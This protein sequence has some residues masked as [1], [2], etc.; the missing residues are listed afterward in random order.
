MNIYACCLLEVIDGD[1]I[2][3]HVSFG[4]GFYCDAYIRLEE[5]DAPEIFGVGKH[6]EEYKRGQIAKLFVKQWFADYGEECILISNNRG[7]HGRWLGFIYSSN[8]SSCLN[9]FMIT[10]GYKNK[11]GRMIRFEKINNR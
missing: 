11:R 10:K 9:T 7:C 1:T 3:V 8:F 4:L 5:I 2:T 6:S